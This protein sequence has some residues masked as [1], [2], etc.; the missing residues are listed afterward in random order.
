GKADPKTTFNVGMVE[1]GT[2]ENAKAENASMLMEFRT[3]GENVKMLKARLMEAV[4]E[5]VNEENQKWGPGKE[6]TVEHHVKVA[7]P[8]GRTPADA[9]IVQAAAAAT[10]AIGLKPKYSVTGMT[11]ANYSHGANVPG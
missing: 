1:G 6:V 7:I 10:T 2:A 3:D 5:A 11:D 8:G 4:R 9:G